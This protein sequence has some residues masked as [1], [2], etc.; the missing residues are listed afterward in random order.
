MDIQTEPSCNRERERIGRLQGSARCGNFVDLVSL[1]SGC[2]AF[3]INHRKFRVPFCTCADHTV[4]VD[5]DT[6]IHYKYVC[7]LHTIHS[8]CVVSFQ[9]TQRSEQRDAHDRHFT[10][11]IALVSSL[12][13]SVGQV[14]LLRDQIDH[15]VQRLPKKRGQQGTLSSTT[16]A[17]SR[18][19]ATASS[20]SAVS[21]T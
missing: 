18:I 12:V 11:P 14:E 2:S 5:Y 4:H 15:V 8:Y 13:E 10:H 21:T 17:V 1:I 7:S 6:C 16:A 20:S 9:H 3:C 19:P